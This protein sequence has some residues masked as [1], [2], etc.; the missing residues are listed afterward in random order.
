MTVTV[1]TKLWIVLHTVQ[2]IK[3]K[4]TQN[5]VRILLNANTDT[6]E[7]KDEIQHEK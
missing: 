2:Q 7:T 5:M 4:T 6:E 1:A 3:R